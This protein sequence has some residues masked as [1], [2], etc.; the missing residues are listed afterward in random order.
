[1][2]AAKPMKSNSYDRLVAHRQIDALDKTGRDATITGVDAETV[3]GAF[4][5]LKPVFST[6]C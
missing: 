1:M 6:A 5:P 4:M 2:N 3:A